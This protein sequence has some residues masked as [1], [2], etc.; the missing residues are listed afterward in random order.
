MRKISVEINGVT[1]SSMTEAAKILGISLATVCRHKDRGTFV[2]MKKGKTNPKKVSIDGR[3]YNSIREAS[4][5]IG[6][7]FEKLRCSLNAAN[8]L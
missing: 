2:N 3:T 1:Y 4:R 8:F 5:E 7:N 6:V